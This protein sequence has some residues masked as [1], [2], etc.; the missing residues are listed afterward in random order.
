MRLEEAEVYFSI[1]HPHFPFERSHLRE[2]LGQQ[3]SPLVVDLTALWAGPL[4]T[5]LLAAAGA[6]VVKVE[7]RSRP[8]GARRGNAGFY[9]LLN[10]G[11][12]CVTVDFDDRADVSFLRTLLGSADLVVEASRP[13]V[14]DRLGIDP[15]AL[16][17]EGVSWVS[18]TGHGR[19]GDAAFKVVD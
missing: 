2:A 13:R 14:M 11:K 15:S 17:A 3:A 1:G 12:E 10:H 16:A 19:T 5:S 6:R 9:D 8:D 18:I 4:L 7:G